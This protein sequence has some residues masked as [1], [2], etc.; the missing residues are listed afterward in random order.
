MIAISKAFDT[1][2]KEIILEC[3]LMFDLNSFGD[4]LV[5]GQCNFLLASRGL[6]NNLI[7][8]STA[9]LSAN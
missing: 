4:V 5:K 2:C 3:R 8:R 7:S 6:D 9:A 1:N